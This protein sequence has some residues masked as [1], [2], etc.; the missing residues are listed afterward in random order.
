MRRKYGQYKRAFQ[1]G[2]FFCTTF[3]HPV[4]KGAQMNAKFLA[5]KWQIDELMLDW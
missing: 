1:A 3:V 4:A 2:N 5:V